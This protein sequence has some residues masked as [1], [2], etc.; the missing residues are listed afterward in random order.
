M[1]LFLRDEDRDERRRA[2]GKEHGDGKQRVGKRNGEVDGAHG[3]FVHADGDHEPV[4]HGVE[5]ED[6]LR[7]HRGGDKTDEVM[8]QTFPRE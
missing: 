7:G 3:V 6:D 8:F 5:R 2:D 1:P 4:D